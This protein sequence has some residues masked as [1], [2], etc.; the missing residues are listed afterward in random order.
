MDMANK[1]NMDIFIPA[2]IFSVLSAEN[3]ALARYTHL[4]IGGF[5][6]VLGSGL[7]LWPLCR[8]LK[9]EPKTF[10]PPMMY[11]NCGNLGLPLALLAFG[12]AALPAAVVLFLV[13]NT[14][15][16]TVG[17]YSL[18]QSAN[19]LNI[20]KMPIVLVTIFGLL[21][22]YMSWPVYPAI[23][24]A[25]DMLGQIAIP[26]MLFTLGI[27]MTEVSFTH[28]RISIIG[29]LLCPL[30]SLI[31]AAGV[32]W[33]LPIPEEQQAYLL[34]FSVLPPA[35]LNFIVAE[36]FKQQPEQV[37]AIV[38]IGNIASLGII[39]LVLWFIL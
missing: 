33:L 18:N 10:L 30:A 15:H 29:A 1:V 39:P 2:F 38:L 28:W 24:T 31:I 23:D 26:L 19:P 12:E 16:F 9:L 14:L 13:S 6:I 32:I 17:I 36:R 22:S 34:L 8:W 4:A 5:I 35:V 25:I 27:R 37:A 7:L 11:N 21:W 20:L 3:F